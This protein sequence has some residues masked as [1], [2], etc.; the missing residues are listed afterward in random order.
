MA[1]LHL[2]K[3]AVDNL[4]SADK[5]LFFYDDKVP[6]FGVKVAKSG[7]KTFFVQGYVNGVQKRRKIGT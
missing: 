1:T 2:I 5:D 7:R 6:G 3:T 4:L